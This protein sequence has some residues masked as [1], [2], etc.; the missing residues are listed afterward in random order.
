MR[1]SE[2][3]CRLGMRVFRLFGLL[4]IALL[5][6]AVAPASDV[7]TAASSATSAATDVDCSDGYPRLGCKIW[8]VTVGVE[9]GF[10]TKGSVTCETSDKWQ[11]MRDLF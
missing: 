7:A 11:C 10:P 2:S 6:L 8:K 9:I 5:L 4:A 3:E 1:I